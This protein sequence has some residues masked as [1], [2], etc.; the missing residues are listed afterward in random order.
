LV[1]SATDQTVTFSRTGT[2]GNTYSAVWQCVVTDSASSTANAGT[3]SISFTFSV[4]AL[5]VSLSGGS[6]TAT[7]VGTGTATTTP[8]I[9]A[10]ASGGTGG[11]SYSWTYV[12]GDSSIYPVSPTSAATDFARFG[13]PEF[14]YTAYYKCVVTD[15]SSNT[16]SSQD[17]TVIID[18]VY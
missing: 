14:S 17:V 8:T 6:A 11:Y 10:T 18:F 3:V 4:P 13:S 1:S 9:T 2:A 12:S 5:S 15:S 7:Q 16:A